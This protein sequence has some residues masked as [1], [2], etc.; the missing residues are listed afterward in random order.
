MND[1]TTP[2]Y[3]EGK[4]GVITDANHEEVKDNKETPSEE[5]KTNNEIMFIEK[6]RARPEEAKAPQRG[7]NHER[8]DGDIIYIE[9]IKVEDKSEKKPKNEVNDEDKPLDFLAPERDDDFDFNAFSKEMFAVFNDMRV[10][11][12]NYIGKTK[13]KCIIIS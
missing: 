1:D 4:S 9:E 5:A 10:N 2:G 7:P 12:E 13:R 3:K 8:S 11:P 6:S